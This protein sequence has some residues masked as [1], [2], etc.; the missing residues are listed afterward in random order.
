VGVKVRTPAGEGTIERVV[1]F[2]EHSGRTATKAA[3]LFIVAGAAW[4]ADELEV[5]E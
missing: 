4:G 5:I 3:P 2:G 1:R